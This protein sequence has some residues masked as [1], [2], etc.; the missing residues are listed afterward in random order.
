MTETQVTLM[1]GA[2]FVILAMSLIIYFPWAHDKHMK[3]WNK[4]LKGE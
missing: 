2:V 4:K 1:L 3:E